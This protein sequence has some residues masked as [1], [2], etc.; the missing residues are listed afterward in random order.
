[1]PSTSDISHLVIA[2]TSVWKSAVSAT[3]ITPNCPSASTEKPQDCSL[4]H[5]FSYCLCVPLHA[6]KWEETEEA[7]KKGKEH[8]AENCDCFDQCTLKSIKKLYLSSCLK[9]HLR[10]QKTGLWYQELLQVRET[11]LRVSLWP[12]DKGCF[13]TLTQGPPYLAKLSQLK[14]HEINLS[15]NT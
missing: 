8:L 12:D 9:C 10:K 11:A 7:R 1:M 4:I 14:W 15:L 6:F 3:A 13:V 2:S 5:S